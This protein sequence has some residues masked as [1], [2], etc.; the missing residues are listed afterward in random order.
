MRLAALARSAQTDGAQ[1]SAAGRKG[2]L[3]RFETQAREL[4]DARLATGERIRN[5]AAEIERVAR[6]LLTLHMT[7]LAN[8]PRSPRGSKA[9]KA[10]KPATTKQVKNGDRATPLAA[11]DTAAKP[12]A[13]PRSRPM[14]SKDQAPARSS[15]PR[16]RR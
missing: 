3:R 13:T 10:N 2:F 4:V 5:V 11:R 15:T 14:K 6:T 16:P 9:S 1:I 12:S 7:E 8:R